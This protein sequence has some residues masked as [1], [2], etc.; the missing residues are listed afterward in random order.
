MFPL[1]VSCHGD[2]SQEICHCSKILLLPQYYFHH[3]CK[4]LFSFKICSY[5][6]ILK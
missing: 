5:V 3:L 2:R 1:L 4:L 6:K